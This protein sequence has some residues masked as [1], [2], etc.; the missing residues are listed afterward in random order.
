MFPKIRELSKNITVYGLGD[1]AVSIVNFLLLSVYVTYFSAEAYGVIGILGA[2]EVIAKIVFRFGL[3]GSFMRFFYD[4]KDDDSRRR[5][6]S[7]IFF[8]LLA[9]NGAVVA[10]LIAAAPRLADA[11]LGSRAYTPALRLMLLNTFAIGFTFIPFHVLRMERKTV[12]FSLLTLVRAVLT[13]AVRLVLVMRL[14]MGVTGL[15]LA[16][17]L[18]T[19]VVMASLV[20]SFAP[21]IRPM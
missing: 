5:L 16:D 7:T 8:F 9:L 1:V 14:D 11:F 20:P 15:Y 2:M 3:D 21:L 6:A 18:V 13:I 4:C 17:V 12:T 19:I 10:V